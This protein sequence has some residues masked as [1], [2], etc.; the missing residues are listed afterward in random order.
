MQPW[1]YS[2]HKYQYKNSSSLILNPSYWEEQSVK[3]RVG[4]TAQLPLS[5]LKRSPERRLRGL[6]GADKARMLIGQCPHQSKVSPITLS[7]G[8]DTPH[9]FSLAR[10]VKYLYIT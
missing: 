5:R 8:A 3:G 2:V 1:T 10:N 9:P 7:L 4:I 6:Q